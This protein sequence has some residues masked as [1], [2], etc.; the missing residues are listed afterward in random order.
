MSR[1]ASRA[2]VLQDDLAILFETTQL[3]RHGG[4]ELTFT[5]GDRQLNW[6]VKC[7]KGGEARPGHD[8]DPA[9]L[10]LTR[11][12]MSQRGRAREYSA[13]QETATDKH[14]KP[15]TDAQDQPAPIVKPTQGVAENA[16]EPCGQNPSGSCQGT[17]S[18][19]RALKR[20][21]STSKDQES[22]PHAPRP[23]HPPRP[24][25]MMP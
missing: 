23:L 24:A 18:A 5:V 19:S 16:P 17:T 22:I 25:R 6:L 11:I 8:V 15:V 14:L 3:V 12:V 21:D 9:S 10:E 13:G 2:S 4:Q 1:Q 7:H 20:L